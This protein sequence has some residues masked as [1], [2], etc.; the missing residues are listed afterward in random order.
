MGTGAMRCVWMTIGRGQRW[1]RLE[2]SKKVASTA[3]R[4]M[5]DA[6]GMLCGADDAVI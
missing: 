3:G 4:A 5:R 2:E 6:D 1:A